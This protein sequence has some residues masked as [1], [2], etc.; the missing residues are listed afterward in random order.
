MIFCYKTFSQ[1]DKI[2][3]LKQ[4]KKKLKQIVTEADA[5]PPPPIIFQKSPLPAFT[6]PPPPVGL[7]NFPT[8]QEICF[9]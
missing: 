2:L 6:A 8:E 1:I 5:P 9:I 4:T 3:K 7:Q